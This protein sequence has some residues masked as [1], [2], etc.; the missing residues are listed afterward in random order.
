MKASVKVMRSYDYCHFEV[1]LS[2]DEEMDLD[3]V[4]NLRKQAAILVDEAV[5]QY[6]LAKKAE[7]SRQRHDWDKE[8][9]IERAKKL[10]DK[11]Q[12][13]WSIEDAAFMRSYEDKEFWR[14]M[15]QDDYCYADDPE[16][17]HH[18]SMLRKFQETRISA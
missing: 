12:S 4:N 9:A 18:F 15:E 7:D 11:P 14:D 13:E 17:D 8:R 5:R 16:R 2:S 1:A 10:S 3:Q 6:R